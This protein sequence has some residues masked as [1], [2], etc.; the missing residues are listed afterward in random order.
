MDDK[1]TKS[2]MGGWCKH[3]PGDKINPMDS[4]FSGWTFL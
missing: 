2:Q 4:W 3:V 1:K